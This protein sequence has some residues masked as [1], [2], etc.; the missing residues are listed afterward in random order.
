MLRLLADS[1]PAL[2]AYF[3]LAEQRCRFANRRYAEYFGLT[4]TTIIGKTIEEVG[5]TKAWQHVEPHVQVLRQGQ[6]VRYTRALTMP[7]GASRMIE[8]DLQPHFDE[9]QRL[10]GGYVLINDIT[11]RWHA[12]RALRESEER[13]AKFAHASNEGLVFH[14]RG[15]IAD[16]ND[17]MLRMLGFALDEIKGRSVLEF[18]PESQP[19]VSG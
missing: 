8:V 19:V 15:I 17:A 2:I 6:S 16:A 11:D 5:G 4:T 14:Q 7:D 10:V 3:D 13:S 1:L 18:I 12:E 9:A